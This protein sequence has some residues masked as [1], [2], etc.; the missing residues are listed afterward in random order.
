M[1]AGGTGAGLL[2]ARKRTY[3]AAPLKQ[4]WERGSMKM[5]LTGEPPVPLLP[6]PSWPGG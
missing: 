1:A 4:M 5:K 6:L 2:N 3:P